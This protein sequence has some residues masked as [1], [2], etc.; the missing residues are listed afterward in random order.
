MIAGMFQDRVGSTFPMHTTGAERGQAHAPGTVGT[1]T[2]AHLG[3]HG[4]RKF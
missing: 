2:L 4:T 1:H 3:C